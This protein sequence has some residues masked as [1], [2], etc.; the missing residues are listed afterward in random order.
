MRKAMTY[1]GAVAFIA[2]LAIYLVVGA[3][4][5][6]VSLLKW[7]VPGWGEVGG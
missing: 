5:G 4:N 7:L 1:I 3:W 6:A 2:F